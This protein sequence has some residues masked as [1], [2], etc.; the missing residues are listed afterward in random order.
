VFREGQITEAFRTYH[1]LFEAMEN[2]PVLDESDYSN[3]EYQAT[4]ENIGLS[5]RSL[6]NDYDLPDEW[7]SEV[8]SWFW[9][10]NQ[11][12]VENR[13]DQGGWPSEDNLREAFESL[14]YELID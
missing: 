4:L 2:Y 6:K 1:E 8:F 3:R 12:A 11:S 5:A 9:E 13:D 10:N 14:G 7:E